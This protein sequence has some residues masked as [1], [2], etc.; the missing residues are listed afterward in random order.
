MDMRPQDMP[1]L[2][3]EALLWQDRHA[4]RMLKQWTPAADD[5]MEGISNAGWALIPGLTSSPS[6]DAVTRLL[7]RSEIEALGSA[8]LFYVSGEMLEL[9]RSAA[10]AL[11]S[12]KVQPEDI[13]SPA[14]L[15]LFDCDGGFDAGIR[16]DDGVSS[17]GIQAVSWNTLTWATET[18]GVRL[19][20]YV[21]QH[22]FADAM[23]SMDDG[24]RAA[25]NIRRFGPRLV[26][27]PSASLN[28]PF[29]ERGWEKLPDESAAAAILPVMLSAWL[30]M[31]QE[32]ALVS[33]VAPDRAARKR[34]RRVG[35]EPKPV[36]VIELRRPK[37]SGEPGD[38]ESNYHHQWIVRGHWR[39]QWH[40]KREVHRPVW[41]APHIKGPEGA[42]LIGG[43]KVYAWKR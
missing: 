9:A 1:E 16:Y 34:L 25:E 6:R 20:P 18:G 10:R 26:C 35:Q 36:R 12:F 8:D 42:P 40:P 29:G 22:H 23:A 38:G 19:T 2:R 37:S 14:G 13:P 33:E 28:A 30:L 7:W 17:A 39:Q 15:M 31:K 4:D 32:L 5:H 11:P 24:Q 3:A 27:L 43:E 41:I 21:E